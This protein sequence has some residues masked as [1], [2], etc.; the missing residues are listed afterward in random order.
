[1]TANH[2]NGSTN[3]SENSDT[4]KMIIIEPLFG[5]TVSGWVTNTQVDID[6]TVM[7][8]PFDTIE[9]AVEWGKQLINASIEPVYVPAYNRG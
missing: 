3:M 9:K 1:M 6:S 8:G 5:Q 4:N 7:Y 2:T